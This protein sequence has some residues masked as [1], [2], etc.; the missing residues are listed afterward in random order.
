MTAAE[1]Q[2]ALV[3][4]GYTPVQTGAAAQARR[5]ALLK[6]RRLKAYSR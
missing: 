2:E 5:R 4:S 6:I 3:E 1:L